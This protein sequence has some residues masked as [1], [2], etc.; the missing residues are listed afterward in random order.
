MDDPR[1]G[2]KKTENGMRLLGL[3]FPSEG[4]PSPFLFATL[5]GAF[6]AFKFVIPSL[7]ALHAAAPRSAPP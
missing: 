2:Q 1:L 7:Q 6:A 5:S 4:P 3:S